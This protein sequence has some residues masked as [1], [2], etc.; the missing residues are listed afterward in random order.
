M[1]L[2]IIAILFLTSCATT[3]TAQYHV[4]MPGEGWTREKIKGVDAAWF[5]PDHAAIMINSSCS[6]ASDVSLIGLTGQLFIG[7]TEQKLINQRTLQASGREA[8]ET[9]ISAKIDG[10]PRQMKT[11][12]LKKDGC[13]YD[14]VLAAPDDAFESSVKTYDLV[15]DS[16]EAGSANE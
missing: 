2:I 4:D 6:D 9:H 14:I 8:L 13:V 1:H 3:R 12:V 15:R 11:W 10:V 16:F 5:S 7:L